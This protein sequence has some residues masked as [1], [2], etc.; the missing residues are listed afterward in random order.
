VREALL[1]GEHLAGGAAAAVAP[2]GRGETDVAGALVLEVLLEVRELRGGELAVVRV[3]RRE[4]RELG[5]AVDPLPLEGVVGEGRVLVRGHLLGEEGVVPGER[6]DLRQRG[7]VAEG[8]GQPGLLGLEAELIEEE[9]LDRKSSR[10]NYSVV[11]IYD[12]VFV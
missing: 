6:A 11:S 9:L 5:G 7:G 2:A 3:D 8:V 10:L 4:V 1:R 12:V